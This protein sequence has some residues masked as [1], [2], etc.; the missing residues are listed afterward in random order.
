MKLVYPVCFL[1]ALCFVMAPGPCT[2]SPSSEAAVSTL[3]SDE[4]NSMAI[5]ME[6]SEPSGG[7]TPSESLPPAG[8]SPSADREDEP[9]QTFMTE[10]PPSPPNPKNPRQPS[11][12]RWNP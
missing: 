10:V 5:A 2:G 6:S 12:T 4:A 1:L 11:L 3:P 8:P 7:E 9:V